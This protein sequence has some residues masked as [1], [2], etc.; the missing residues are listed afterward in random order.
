MLATC[1]WLLQPAGEGAQTRLVVR[2]RYRYPRSAS[3]LWHLVEPVSFVMEKRMF[4]GLKSRAEA[5]EPQVG[6]SP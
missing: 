5:A 6:S 4:Q 1:Q 2:Q 3:A